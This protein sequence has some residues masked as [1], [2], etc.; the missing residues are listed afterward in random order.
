[1]DLWR[2]LADTF[3]LAWSMRGKLLRAAFSSV[4]FGRRSQ[5]A[6]YYDELGDDIV[7]DFMYDDD[8]GGTCRNGN[9][10][11]INIGRAD[12]CG[13]HAGLKPGRGTDD[14]RPLW[15]NLGLWSDVRQSYADAARAMAQEVAER[16]QV[17]PGARVLEVGAGFGEFARLL[18]ADRGARVFAVDMTPLHVAVARRRLKGLAVEFVEGDACALPRG[19]LAAWAGSEAVDAV[20][21]LECAFHFD[22]RERFLCE[23]ASVLRPGGRIAGTDMLPT[24]PGGTNGLLQRLGRW[25]TVIPTSN[26]VDR[27][28]LA[29]QLEAAGFCDVRVESVRLRVFP[30]FTVLGTGR[31]AIA[32]YSGYSPDELRAEVAAIATEPDGGA[33]VWY[34][35]TGI[36]DYVIFSGTKI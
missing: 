32:A 15:L 19:P 17:A 29:A 5:L 20:V 12:A 25:Y 31:R 9:S 1:M 27:A 14:G 16:A 6:A 13:R 30:Y 4:V 22:T 3:W 26:M 33:D 28:T 34:R 18:A 23:A 36:S 35:F 21:A 8:D 7:E 2:T 11:N 24:T 10:G